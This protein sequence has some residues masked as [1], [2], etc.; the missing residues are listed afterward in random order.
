MPNENEINWG[1][2]SSLRDVRRPDVI[3]QERKFDA[4]VTKILGKPVLVNDPRLI[5]LV[6]KWKKA[7]ASSA[8]NT[9]RMDYYLYNPEFLKEL[10]EVFK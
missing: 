5:Q 6:V 7:T 2:A 8:D 4:E 3:K 1:E 10:H 9:D